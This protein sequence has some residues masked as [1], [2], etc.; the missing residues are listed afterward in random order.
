MKAFIS[1]RMNDRPE[2]EILKDFE[3]AFKILKDDLSNQE[4]IPEGETLELIDS[5]HHENVPKDAPRLYYL[6]E[7]IKKLDDADVVYFYK[8]WWKAKGCWVEFIAANVYDK[9]LVYDYPSRRIMRAIEDILHWI[10]GIVDPIYPI[11]DEEDED[12]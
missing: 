2:N 1:L 11:D 6:G 12:E 3:S 5:F 9:T 10:F 7:A 4:K 8:D